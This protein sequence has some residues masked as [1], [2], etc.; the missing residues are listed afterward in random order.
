MTHAPPKVIFPL[1]KRRKFSSRN[2]VFSLW[3]FRGEPSSD[4]AVL[5]AATYSVMEQNHQGIWS[6]T[7]KKTP[8]FNTKKIRKKKTF[9][10]CH[11]LFFDYGCCLTKRNA[12][13]TKATERSRQEKALYN[14]LQFYRHLLIVTGT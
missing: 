14:S 3:P 6:V 11:S 12:V 8:G 13:Y 2:R 7:L 5:T 9:L 1:Q 10:V 4:H